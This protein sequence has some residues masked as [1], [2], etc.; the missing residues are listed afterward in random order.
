MGCASAGWGKG[1]APF[2]LGQAPQAM[3]LLPCR[4]GEWTG[5]REDRYHEL[6]DKVR[7]WLPHAGGPPH[8]G[9]YVAS[10]QTTGRG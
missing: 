6:L 9:L 2:C 5:F 10:V 3:A 1:P 8:S 7:H 4:S